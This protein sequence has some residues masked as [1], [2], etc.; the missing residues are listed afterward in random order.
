MMVRKRGRNKRPVRRRR[1][2]QQKGGILP[3]LIPL[4]AAGKIAAAKAA[5][6]AAAKAAATGAVGAA[7]GYGTKCLMERG[8][9]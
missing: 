3:F 7:A 6:V 2:R 1:Q 9:R 5:A 4:I 8:R